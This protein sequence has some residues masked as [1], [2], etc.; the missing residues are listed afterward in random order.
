[1]PA[2][3]KKSSKK[4]KAKDEEAISSML[5]GL[6]IDKGKPELEYYRALWQDAS[7]NHRETFLI[8]IDG[9]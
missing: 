5:K 7:G 3:P 4:A 2:R 9:A 6:K 1:M 8:K